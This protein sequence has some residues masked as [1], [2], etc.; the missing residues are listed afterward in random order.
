MLWKVRALLDDRPGAMAALA[1]RCGDQ[2]VNIL[3]LQIF[4]AADGRVVDELVL[5]TPGG[6]SGTDVEQ[7][8]VLAG[9]ATPTVAP[10]S[11]HAL[12]DEPVR[13][14]RAAQVVAERPEQ[15]QEQLCRLL[16]ASPGEGLPG[17][18]SLALTAE[19]GAALS[20]SRATAFTDTE[21]A[22]AQ[23]LQRV[24]SAASAAVGT[25]T[26]AETGP[27]TLRAGSIAD[28]DALVALHGRCSSETLYRRYHAPIAHVTPRMVR[29]Q[30]EPTGGRSIVLSVGD[31]VV[32]AA[33]YSVDPAS[34]E[35]GAVEVGLM[36][37]DAW[38]RQGHGARL[39][40]ALAV[41]AAEQGVE[42][43]TCFVQPENDAAVLRTIRRAG[44]RARVSLADGLAEYRIPVGRPAD[45]G[46]A[47]RRRRNNR[48]AMGEVTTPLVAL[49]QGRPELREV[50]PPAAL[51]DQAVRGGA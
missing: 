22:R 42:T 4:P 2:G 44:L 34:T 19:D 30:L 5:H 37:E 51:I 39:L 38:Q 40:H 23:E 1:A 12:E 43:L 31:R 15:L 21:V 6:W 49:L 14:L 16:D 29:A 18:D 26:P 47:P 36:V 24:A 3:G 7:L 11:P 50:Y 46:E 35:P 32:A 33:M 9:V 25:A 17:F 41:Q 8:C 13:Y 45:G 28:T 20:L 48:P 27:V 10:C